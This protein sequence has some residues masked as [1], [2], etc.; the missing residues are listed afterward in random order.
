ME[1]VFN[2]AE[3][4]RYMQSAVVVSGDS[5]VLL[6]HFLDDAKELDVDAVSDG[7][8]VVIGGVMQHI[9]Q[10]GVH[11]GDSA[12]SIPP[13]DLK[14]ETIDELRRQTKVMA[15]E[16]GVIGLMN[17][18]FAVKGD[19]VYVLRQT[20]DGV[21]RALAEAAGYGFAKFITK[22]D[23]KILGAHIVGPHA[24]E[25]IHEAV[26]AMSQNLKVS[27]L[28]CIHVYPT[29]SEITPKAALQLTKQKF[30]SNTILQNTFRKFFNWRRSVAG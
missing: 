30:A 11:S 24:G 29:L 5:P 25:L 15:K 1:I 21:D 14:P 3:L 18:Q 28:Q 6:D 23:G 22:G 27:A 13:Y 7:T 8:D 4:K 19:D 26:I 9:E 20:F 10:A 17:V 16:L 12:C 2:D